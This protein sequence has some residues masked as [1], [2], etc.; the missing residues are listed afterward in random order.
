MIISFRVAL[1]D[2]SAE[3]VKWMNRRQRV[4]HRQT[5]DIKEDQRFVIVAYGAYECRLRVANHAVFQVPPPASPV[6][7]GVLLLSS[8][9]V[10]SHFGVLGARRLQKRPVR[11]GDFRW[12]TSFSRC[13]HLPTA[14]PW[15][16]TVRGCACVDIMRC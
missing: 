8:L 6:N 2:M 7:S 9:F 16:A 3:H 12:S 11:T 10:Y 5:G 14:I 15:P 13:V 4:V 1:A